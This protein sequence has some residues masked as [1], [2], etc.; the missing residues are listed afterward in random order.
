MAGSRLAF[1][2][3]TRRIVGAEQVRLREG[4]PSSTVGARAPEA[5]SVVLEVPG[6]P[7]RPMHLEAT[8]L[9]TR[10]FDDWDL[11]VLALASQLAAILLEIERARGLR[12]LAVPL[13][14]DGAAPLIGS[15]AIMRALRQKVERVA[16]TDFTIL[17]EGG[18]GPQPHPDVAV[19][20]DP[21]RERQDR[22]LA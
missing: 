11:Q 2:E 14:R 3:T 10:R 12:P 17:I 6:D 15:T 20:R 16:A 22:A 8:A 5:T 1:E 13:P 4:R 19:R 9:P 7:A 21:I 18:S